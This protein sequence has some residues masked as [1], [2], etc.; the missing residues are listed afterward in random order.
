MAGI[1]A[2][3]KGDFRSRVGVP[4]AWAA[5]QRA[6]S[7]LPGACEG[8][9]APRAHPRT[10]A[11][12]ERRAASPAATGAFSLLVHA[13]ALLL[14]FVSRTEPPVAPSEWSYQLV[15]E[16]VPPV[17]SQPASTA[18]GPRVPLAPAPLAEMPPAAR[19][20][21]ETSLPESPPEL[22]PAERPIPVP[23]EDPQ[24]VPEAPPVRMQSPSAKRPVAAN[25][26]SSAG[27][28]SVASR[29]PPTTP[30]RHAVPSETPS[31]AVDIASRAVA[32]PIVPPSPVS[33]MA[34]NRAPAY[35]ESALR[36]R[37]QGRVVLRVSVSVDGTPIEVG[38]AETSGHA[39]LDA[40][41]LVAVRQWRFSPATQAGRA[42]PAI[43]EVPVR[44]RLDN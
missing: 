6:I 28:S 10:F 34:T 31:P 22:P 30:P 9:P 29:V 16:S 37:E 7:W 17:M 44:F 24:S 4:T 15:F 35:P 11:G 43:A 20:L 33:G 1:D 42:V 26:N 3:I 5:E 25:S 38:L 23:V 14:L 21:A 40:A 8:S 18:A 41:A 2:A 12:P 36:R 32:I 19:P 27:P 13:S 39:S